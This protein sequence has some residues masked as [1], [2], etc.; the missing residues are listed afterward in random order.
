[1]L[2]GGKRV[3]RQNILDDRYAG[4]FEKGQRYG[5]LRLLLSKMI[6]PVENRYSTMER[7]IRDLEEVENWEQK[8]ARGLLNSRALESTAQLQRRI[9]DDMQSQDL[10]EQVRQEDIARIA[11]V[12]TSVVEWVAQQ[13]EATK[14]TL[15]TGGMLAVD[16][17]LG[18]SGATRTVQIDTGNNTLLEERARATI[19]I[20]LP[21]DPK[22]TVYSLQLLVCAEVNYNMGSAN[23]NYLGKPG[24]PMM[25]V[26]PMFGQSSGNTPPNAY[27]EAGYFFG[28]PTKF[29]V[30][31]PIPMTTARTYNRQMIDR[32]YHDGMMAIARFVALDWPAA[33][34]DVQQMMSE[35]LSRMM[36]YINQGW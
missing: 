29:G 25:A 4:F 34:D 13:L 17:N 11:A 12:A 1:M 28:K 22:W 9:A 2:S 16:V 31:D 7:V 3:T 18:P 20:R 14:V 36:D 30:P 27:S 15:E 8:V 24:N 35:V 23:A 5:L 26:V 32:G 19:A 6:A 33:Q 10:F 21:R